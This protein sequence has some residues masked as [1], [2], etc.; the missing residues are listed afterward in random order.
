MKDLKR[1]FSLTL[2]LCVLCVGAFAADQRD[3]K[4]DPPPKEPVVIEKRDKEPKRDNP[5]RNDN[6]PKDDNNNRRRPD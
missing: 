4:R 5:P 6:R 3:Q 1:I 2:M